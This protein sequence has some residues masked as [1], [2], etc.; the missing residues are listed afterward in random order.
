MPKLLR[1]LGNPLFHRIG[2]EDYHLEE[3]ISAVGNQG[4]QDRS[5]SCITTE[6]YPW[7][8]NTFETSKAA[9]KNNLINGQLLHHLTNN[10]TVYIVWSV[11]PF[12][13]E[14]QEFSQ[15]GL[16]DWVPGYAGCGPPGVDGL[17]LT[18]LSS[19]VRII[20]IFKYINWI[21][22]SMITSA[23]LISTCGKIWQFQAFK[24]FSLGSSEW[25]I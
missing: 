20:N 18:Y 24:F 19:R 6:E 17:L 9:Q 7:A 25:N 13:L 23:I 12:R 11:H 8:V 2:S 1:I 5:I 22:Y 4:L 16:R 10:R 21:L 15:L 3:D 14:K